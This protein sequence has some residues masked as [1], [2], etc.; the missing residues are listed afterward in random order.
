MACVPFAI[1]A[2]RGSLKGLPTETK[3][4]KSKCLVSNQKY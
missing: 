4:K 2:G 3:K 1:V